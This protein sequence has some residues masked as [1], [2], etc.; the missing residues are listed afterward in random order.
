VANRGADRAWRGARR[1]RRLVPFGQR[2]LPEADAVILAI[3]A[4]WPL[5]PA[6][7]ADLLAAACPVMDLSSPPAVDPTSAAR[8]ERYTSVDDP[9]APRGDIAPRRATGT[10]STPR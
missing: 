7:R 9:P 8:R 2:P 10:P 5:S 4:T 6:A 1:E 3:S